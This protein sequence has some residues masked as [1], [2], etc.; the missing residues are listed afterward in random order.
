MVTVVKE[1][2]TPTVLSDPAVGKSD[3]AVG[4]GATKVKVGGSVA[5]G[6]IEKV[7]RVE[8]TGRKV[9]GENGGVR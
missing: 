8:D 7:R 4:K 2:S 6:H 9:R 5:G 1:D 3:F